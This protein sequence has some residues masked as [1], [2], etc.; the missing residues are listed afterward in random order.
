MKQ[1]KINNSR[2][3][4]LW[5][6]IPCTCHKGIV[7]EQHPMKECTF[8]RY[9]KCWNS[10]PQKEFSVK[11]RLGKTKKVNEITLVRGSKEDVIGWEFET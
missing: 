6:S 3:K 4:A 11:D 5:E 1:F 9:E 8:C 2:K 7:M 10:V